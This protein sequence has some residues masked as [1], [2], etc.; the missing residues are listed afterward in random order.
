M[1]AKYTCTR[2][3]F[4]HIHV[5]NIKIKYIIGLIIQQD[6]KFNCDS[7]SRHGPV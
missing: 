7:S 6:C 4:V 5:L 1:L 2:K 3:I